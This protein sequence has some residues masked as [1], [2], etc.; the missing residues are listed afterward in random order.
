MNATHQAISS[1][2]SYYSVSIR[3]FIRANITLY[4]HM[5]SACLCWRRRARLDPCLYPAAGGLGLAPRAL[6]IGL[7]ATWQKGRVRSWYDGKKWFQQAPATGYNLCG[8]AP[9][10]L[11]E[12]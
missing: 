5:L 12:A 10:L 3:A 11:W 4:V 1:I 6:E 9:S 7:S 8:G 2:I